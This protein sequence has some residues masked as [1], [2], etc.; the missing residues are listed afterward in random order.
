MSNDSKPRS[1]S[2][3]ALF[4]LVMAGFAVM[5][6]ITAA[7]GVVGF[8]YS[9][10]MDAANTKLYNDGLLAVSYSSVIIE[11]FDHMRL[12]LHSLILEKGTATGTGV[13]KRY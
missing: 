2:K 7:V 8:K 12:S 5:V 6:I 11:R 10:A 13:K 4:G 1:K 9:R 3:L